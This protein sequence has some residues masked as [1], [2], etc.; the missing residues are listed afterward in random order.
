MKTRPGPSA[1]TAGFTLI[2]VLVAIIVLSLGLLGVAGMQ[3]AGL[4]ASQS[5]YLRTLATYQA[6]DMADRMRANLQGVNGGSYNNMSGDP[7]SPGCVATNCTPAQMA[8]NDQHEWSVSNASILPS[9]TGAVCLDSTPDD[10]T[11]AAPACDGIGATFAVKVWWTD[12]KSG[13][14]KRFATSF[15]P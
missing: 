5:S 1:S 7:G 4:R 14:P 8:Q 12:D 10:G 15:Q 3:L 11:P 6:Y 2:E 13:N 9:G